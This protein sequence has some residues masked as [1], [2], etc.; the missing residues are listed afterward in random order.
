M[1]SRN[2][3][4]YVI[5][6]TFRRLE[7]AGGEE[8]SR[9]TG[10][11]GAMLRTALSLLVAALAAA[12]A[13]AAWGTTQDTVHL[14]PAAGFRPYS[15]SDC[16]VGTGDFLH[17]CGGSGQFLAPLDLPTGAFFDGITL[18]GCD[19]SSST[20]MVAGIAECDNRNGDFSTCTTVV[21]THSSGSGSTNCYVWGAPGTGAMFTIDNVNH[22]YYV[23]VSLDDTTGVEYLRTVRIHYKLQVSPAPAT[24]TFSDV[25]TTS[26]QFRFVEALVAAGITAG[27]GGGNFC[28][29]QPITRGQMAVFLASAL[30]LEWN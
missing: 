20:D 23:F 10:R 2:I 17:S 24:A 25:P 22:S 6:F 3:L 13:L 18:E 21:T 29:D 7:A 19:F 11:A 14:I 5:G 12:P 9:R 28:P 15:G 30:G 16:W 27:C 8:E 26:P 1:R 4:G